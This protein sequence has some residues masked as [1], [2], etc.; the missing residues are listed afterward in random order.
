[1]SIVGCV[2]FL[3]TDFI[4]DRHEAIGLTK[5]SLKQIRDILTARIA[6][7]H[8]RRNELG[9]IFAV[10]RWPDTINLPP[11]TEGGIAGNAVTCI[12]HIDFIIFSLSKTQMPLG[13]TN[14]MSEPSRFLKLPVL[15]HQEYPCDSSSKYGSAQKSIRNRRVWPLPL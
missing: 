10:Y 3:R 9:I 7:N 13:K 5:G 6:F 15:W 11:P 4:G 1:M 12:R 8:E 14:R 2:R